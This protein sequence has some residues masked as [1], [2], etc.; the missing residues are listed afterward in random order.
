[1]A[2]SSLVQCALPLFQ[3]LANAFLPGIAVWPGGHAAV[4]LASLFARQRQRPAWRSLPGSCFASKARQMRFANRHGIEHSNQIAM[5]RPKGSRRFWQHDACRLK[6]VAEVGRR[7]SV[8]S[9]LAAFVIFDGL[10]REAGT[11]R[12]FL[13]RPARRLPAGPQ[14]IATME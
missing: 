5:S 1:M 2:K 12:Q 14:F 3:G 4:K 8:Q 7:N 13:L 9:S 6:C 10:R 11:R